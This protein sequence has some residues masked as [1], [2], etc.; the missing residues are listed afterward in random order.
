MPCD[1]CC[2]GFVQNYE[3]KCKK[4]DNL[5]QKSGCK[6]HTIDENGLKC[7]VCYKDFTN[8]DGECLGN[9]GNQISNCEIHQQIEGKTLC[10]KCI[11]GCQLDHSMTRCISR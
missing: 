11:E 5:L 1:I 7:A 9:N 4:L 3:G 10:L 6:L 2:E 8:V